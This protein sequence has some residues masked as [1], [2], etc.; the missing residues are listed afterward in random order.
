MTKECSYKLLA[1]T[2]MMQDRMA[3]IC[4]FHLDFM[5]HATI[6]ISKEGFGK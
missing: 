3:L 2:E 6:E 4:C 5:G 1:S